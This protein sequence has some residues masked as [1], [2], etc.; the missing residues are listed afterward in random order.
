MAYSGVATLTPNGVPARS[1]KPVGALGSTGR[2]MARPSDESSPTG[3]P[4]GSPFSRQ[5]RQAL[6]LSALQ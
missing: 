2:R 6:A 3:R 4:N 5:S 1:R